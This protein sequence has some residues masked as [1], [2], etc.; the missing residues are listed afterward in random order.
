VDPCLFG[1]DPDPRQFGTDPDPWIHTGTSE[2]RIRIQ[3]LI[4]IRILLLSLA[5]DKMLTK[6]FFLLITVLFG[7]TFITVFKDTKSRIS[8]KMIEIKFITQFFRLFKEESGKKKM[9]DQDPGVP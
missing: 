5:A 9:A 6:S 4:R 7:G 1:T 2:L 3:I 8:H